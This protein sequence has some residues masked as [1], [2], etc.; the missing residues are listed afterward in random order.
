[1]FL[2]R[3][4]S[5]SRHFSMAEIDAL[6][7]ALRV[8]VQAK[9]AKMP[10]EEKT[11]QSQA[12]FHKLKNLPVF[13]NSKRVSVY[14]SIEGEIDTEAIVRHIFEQKKE[15][16][17][18]RCT[19]SEMQMVKL[20]SMDDW[21][22]LPYSKWKIKQ[23]ALND[24]RE[25]AMETGGL[26]LMIC[27]GVAF[28][29]TGHRLGYGGGYYDRYQTKLREVQK[30]PFTTVALAFR[31]QIRDEIPVTETDVTLDMVLYDE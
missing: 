27:P 31:E 24:T 14:L 21:L 23:P 20:H 18:P 5:C 19:K 6:K 16:F 12:V 10:R 11:R 8:E 30:G 3:I 9:V 2:F 1:M 22:N 28:T 17:I 15:C 13:Q 25:D 26:D 29:R 4:N 7:K